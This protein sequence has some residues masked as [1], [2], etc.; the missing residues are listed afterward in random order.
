MRGA[1]YTARLIAVAVVV[2]SALTLIALA[3]R[4]ERAP[5]LAPKPVVVSPT[6]VLTPAA[7]SRTPVPDGGQAAPVESTPLHQPNW[8]IWFVTIVAIAPVLIALLFSPAMLWV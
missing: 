8:L 7:G 6:A 3:A 2:L 1:R 5:L 4:S